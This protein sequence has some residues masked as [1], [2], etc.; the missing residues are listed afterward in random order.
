MIKKCFGVI[1]G[2]C[3]CSGTSSW[4]QSTAAADSQTADPKDHRSKT[5][6]EKKRRQQKK[7]SNYSGIINLYRPNYVLPYYYTNNPYDQVYLRQT[8]N[9]QPLRKNEFKAQLSFMVP[10]LHG[11]IKDEPLS[12]NAAYTQLMYWQ[13]YA[14]SQYF[15]ETNYEPEVYLEHY[16]NPFMTAQLGVD[17]Q[18]NGRGG[19]LERSWNR[20]YLQF[21]FSG[22]QWLAHV[23]LWALMMQSESSDLHNPNIAHYLGHDNIVLSRDLYDFKASLEVQNIESGLK[24]GFVLTSLSYPVLNYISIYGQ[25]FTG[26][27][28]SLIEYDHRTTSVGIG[29][30]IHDWIA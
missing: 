6:F 3:L 12:L 24:R 4:A 16:V 19:I 7:T 21:N 8:P 2:M 20:G 10:L 25:F 13:F 14:K 26:Y 23:R 17:H 1:L 22:Q 27:G 30:S 15:R 18:S 29:I 28:Q 9:N 5:L 11:T